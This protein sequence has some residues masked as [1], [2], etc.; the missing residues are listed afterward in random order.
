[1]EPLSPADAAA[2]GTADV[3]ITVDPREVDA[4]MIASWQIHLAIEGGKKKRKG[5]SPNTT[6]L[7]RAPLL[8]A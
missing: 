5:L 2:A 8:A 7:A 3:D 1:M 6:R 4:E